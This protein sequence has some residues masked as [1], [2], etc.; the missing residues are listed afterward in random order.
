MTFS[1]EK[2]ANELNLAEY[3]EDWNAVE[4]SLAR[5]T[6]FYHRHQENGNTEEFDPEHSIRLS[7]RVVT[8]QG[9]AIDASDREKLRSSEFEILGS[10]GSGGMGTVYA[11]RQK[12]V[13][14]EVALKMISP[15]LVGNEECRHSF[16][17]EAVVTGNLSHPNIVAV[18]DLGRSGDGCLFY[19]MQKIIG[20]S[21][22]KVIRNRNEVENLDIL[23]KVCDAVAYAHSK[24]VIHR[25]LKP[26][27]ILLGN[28]GEVILT[29]WG[30][31]VGAGN[32]ELSSKA[33]R[34]TKDSDI[35]GTPAYMP[36][37]MLDPD[38]H[39]I[40]PR[41]DIYLL[42]GILYEIVTGLRPHKISADN[43]IHTIR[44]NLIQPTDK[45]GELVDLARKAMAAD[46]EERYGSVKEFQNA[47][48]NYLIH[49]ES[50]RLT[51]SADDNFETATGNG[52]YQLYAKAMYGYQEA[53]RLWPNNGKA[54][55]TLRLLITGYAERAY[56]NGDFDLALSII[57]Q[58]NRGN[59]DLTARIRAAQ[60]ERERH[61]RKI[62]IMYGGFVFAGIALIA[63]L[64][65]S[66]LLI[67]QSRNKAIAEEQRAR[68]LLVQKERENYYNLIALAA[69]NLRLMNF[70]SAATILE[71]APA[72]LHGP[73]W[74]LLHSLSHP[75]Q[76]ELKGH[77]DSVAAVIYSPDGKYLISGGRDGQV[78]IWDNTNHRLI[79]MLN[80]MIP[81]QRL[82]CSPDSKVV[83][84]VR[85]DRYLSLIHLASG[86]VFRTI[87][88]NAGSISAADFLPGGRR[89][90]FGTSE[91]KL[92]IF[93]IY[94]GVAMQEFPAHKGVISAVCCLPD[95][96]HAVTAGWDLSLKVW[97]LRQCRIVREI[98]AHKKYIDA[99][100]VAP[101]NGIIASGGGD[102]T[103]NLWSLGTGDKIA[104]I[105]GCQDAVNALAF[106]PGEQ[107]LLA[108]AG[109]RITVF[110]RTG[111]APVKTFELDAGVI[112]YSAAF[113]PDGKTV[114]AGDGNNLVSL[115]N[116]DGGLDGTVE[117]KKKSDETVLA[118]S[119]LT[120]ARIC[121][122]PNNRLE[123]RY[124]DGRI[125]VLV[126][127]EGKINA[128]IFLGLTGKI[129]TCSN[130]TTVRIWD[131]D[132]GAMLRV[133]R[134][135]SR[136]V[137]TMAADPGGSI[138]ASASWDGVVK[139]W[140]VSIGQEIR[141]IA[142]HDEA[143]TGLAFSRDGKRLLTSSSDS[144]AKL[145][146]TDGTLLYKMVG[147]TA[148]INAIAFSPD[149]QRAITQSEDRTMRFWDLAT[150][151]EIIALNTGVTSAQR[152]VFADGER[153]LDLIA[154]AQTVSWPL[155]H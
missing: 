100:A 115:W 18:H 120:R 16:L 154:P 151:R 136:Y 110:D 80:F 102:N 150:G 9:D 51:Q 143:I 53:L 57:G 86:E 38:V 105:N 118:E 70:R 131:A 104:A 113:S 1:M 25:D 155:V 82:K 122:I 44:F 4:E 8:W 87:S 5:T 124:P 119:P 103:I 74:Q 27:N 84:A 138:L 111:L 96:V 129:A 94:D 69:N 48:R 88:N 23:L 22:D 52:D 40:G 36:P 85:S 149:G 50:I 32:Y 29:D 49:R 39:R 112:A 89:I 37:E 2:S 13:D 76:T 99:L 24:G 92:T 14:R 83:L 125:N 109:S 134:G 68:Q 91:G 28:F 3:M 66:C 11:A 117:P 64:T 77:T 147:H 78:R 34:L 54:A 55:N 21:W 144:T 106:A 132:T 139:L 123:V 126:G 7:T 81:I 31:A 6:R 15:E 10:L 65:V 26:A 145:W 58:D 41:S 114:A 60:R 43:M 47:L 35:E 19:T 153:R 79:H 45:T 141:S 93:D 90:L 67:G 12:S 152:I 33:I 127:H 116:A 75:L 72:G 142:A 148:Q 140:N 95:G 146:Q 97:D 20:I 46:P 107:Y 137:S 135:H 61:Q 63:I 30:V 71:Q 121:S 17:R 59:A 130:D 133:L 128:A 101:G 42:G 56:A 73:E 98:R 108:S 62:K